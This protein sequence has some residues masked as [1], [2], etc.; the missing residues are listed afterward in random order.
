MKIEVRAD[1]LHISGYVNVTRKLSRP[2]ITPR[3]KVLETIEERA[4]SEAISK[5]GDITVQLDH[6]SGH[7]YAR[8]SDGT[9][10]LREDAIGLHAD[11]LITDETVIEMARKGK[12]RGWSFGMFNVMDEMESRGADELPIRHVKSLELD[13]VSL[14]KD[15]VPCY[16]ATSV[17]CRANGNVDMEL[18]SLDI[19]PELVIENKPD[20]TEYEN[21]LKALG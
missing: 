1:G 17:E 2:V 11:A 4:F 6:D 3:G 7:A 21:R 10:K 12:L 18:R 15:K 13:H 5:S 16:A 8:T 14:I 9:L 19:E 20:F